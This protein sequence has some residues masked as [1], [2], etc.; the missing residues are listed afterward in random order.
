M[1]IKNIF[2]LIISV[3]KKRKATSQFAGPSKKMHFDDSVAIGVGPSAPGQGI[4]YDSTTNEDCVYFAGD[5]CIFE[6][7]LT[8][9]CWT[10][11]I[12]C[13]K[14][15]FGLATVNDELVAIGGVV[16]EKEVKYV[17]SYSLK[18]RGFWV[19]ESYPALRKERNF[20]NVVVYE[21]YLIVV[22]GVVR[23]QPPVASVEV[24]DMI[25]RRSWWIVEL[26]KELNTMTWLS[27]CICSR[28]LYIA[29]QHSDH[30][31]KECGLAIISSLPENVPNDEDDDEFTEDDAETAYPE[32]ECDFSG[33]C[34]CFSLF[35]C[36]LETL[37]KVSKEDRVAAE[38]TD[39][40]VLLWQK[41]NHPHHSVYVNYYKSS[42]PA[43][44]TPG[45]DQEAGYMRYF[46]CRFS[47]AS[48]NDDLVAV[49]CQHIH[50]FTDEDVKT[51]VYDAYESYYYQRR[52]LNERS[53]YQT[54]IIEFK[55][56]ETLDHECH[57]YGYDIESDSWELVINT[58]KNGSSDDRPTLAV[59][60]NKMLILRSS[61]TV[62]IVTF[63]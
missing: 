18:D 63:P 7:N 44:E 56:K 60:G 10:R 11:S 16:D 53:E 33:P 12:K 43:I 35:S 51:K 41:L 28:K 42:I 2:C 27:A 24:L 31:Y 32:Y 8:S 4:I 61:E 39:E 62:H 5:R 58:P 54:R 1:F 30:L 26:P 52:E 38:N 15:A 6:F 13:P 57:I 3:G 34:P 45:D 46:D 17:L 40:T 22:G 14:T 55:K 20:P 29:A 21:K 59:I 9:R 48:V 49:G 47:L 37:V 23:E 36:E 50:S 19:S 25:E